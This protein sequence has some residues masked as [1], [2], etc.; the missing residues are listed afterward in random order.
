MFCR[1]FSNVFHLMAMEFALHAT[2]KCDIKMQ[3][4]LW[5]EGGAEVGKSLTAK[6]KRK[7]KLSLRLTS[8][9]CFLLLFLFSHFICRCKHLTTLSAANFVRLFTR[10]SLTS[11]PFS[12]LSLAFSPCS[13]L[14]SPHSLPFF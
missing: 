9:P 5:H 1:K 2:F 7:R 13:L 6:A 11:L 3:K 4:V 8:C 10:S 12:L 14:L